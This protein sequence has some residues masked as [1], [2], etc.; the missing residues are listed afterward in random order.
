MAAMKPLLSVAV[1]FAFCVSAV[2]AESAVELSRHLPS[3]ANAVAVVRVARLLQTERAKQEG[4]AQ[5]AQYE[6]LTGASRI[7]P[8]VDTLVVGSLVRPAFQQEVWSTAV[9][10]LPGAVTLEQLAQHEESR[11]EQLSGIRAVQS[12]GQAWMIEIQPGLL[13]VRSPA[14]RQEAARWAQLASTGRTGEL[15]TFLQQAVANPAHI[16]LAID[17]QHMADQQ[18]IRNFLEQSNL[19]PSDPVD[20]L[21]LL[22]LL[23]GQQGVSFSV[24]IDETTTAHAVMHFAEAPTGLESALAD[25]FRQHVK[26]HQIWL[27]E[28]DSASVETL[29]NTVHLTMDLSDE[30]L[31]RVVSMIT[32]PS[33]TPPT[34]ELASSTEDSVRPRV[35][36][37]LSPSKRYFRSVSQ[38][39][40]DLARVNRKA[41]DYQ[42]TATWHDNFARRIEQLPTQGVEPSLQAFGRRVADRFRAL[43]ASLRGQGVEINTEQ[44]TLVYDVDYRP[45]WV[46][47]NWWGAVG[48]GE[49]SVKV[50]SNLKEVRERQAA[51]VMKGTRQRTAI[52]RL[53]TD[54]RAEVETSMRNKYGD[55]FFQRRR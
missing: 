28:F 42:R 17:L 36:T 31:R 1:L 35:T 12:R 54:D 10:E 5:T 37:E 41:T 13:G 16:V 2:A 23:G 14:M 39:I 44:K 25:V 7:P 20:R 50:T 43:G 45:G 49:P 4:W 3:D 38:A 21:N 18:R 9:L 40:D 51:A 15:T 29:G 24:T 8:W 34:G 55:K 6:F 52:W 11:V 47:G 32:S 46:A 33:P 30:S 26:D 53:I 22:R 19:L 27:D 48:Y